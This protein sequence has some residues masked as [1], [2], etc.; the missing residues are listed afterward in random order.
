MNGLS[1]L[2]L[3]APRYCLVQATRWDPAT[4]RRAAAPPPLCCYAETPSKLS[5]SLTVPDYVHKYVPFFSGD[6]GTT[7]AALARAM[8]SMWSCS[9][10][11]GANLP[12]L[13]SSFFMS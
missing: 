11:S 9:E 10:V 5:E 2:A 4:I 6:G 12:L 1:A 8:L 7:T 3:C 13:S